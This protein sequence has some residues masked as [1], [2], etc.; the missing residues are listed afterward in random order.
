MTAV[1]KRAK[2][3]VGGSL[4]FG[5]QYLWRASEHTIDMAMPAPSPVPATI[6]C[7]PQD[8]TIDVCRTAIIVIDMQ[9]DF[10]AQGGWVDHLGVDYKPDRAPIA[11]LQRLLPV[12]RKVGVPV[13]WLNWGNRPD[14]ANMPPNQIHLYK[15]HGTGIG[16]GDPLPKSGAHVLEKDS[17][18]A[19]VVDELKREP[20]DI[21][22][23]KYRI[24]GFWDT[25]LD[26]ILRNLGTKSILFAGVNTD[27]CVLHSL[28]D[29]NFLGY[30]CILVDDCCATTSPAF[31][32][33]ATIWN[34]KKCFG[35]VTG[36]AAVIKSLSP[37][38][39]R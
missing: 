17:W 15:P 28:S 35:F 24:S 12:L 30:G 2:Q 21:K 27:Q 10:C 26:S 1:K 6:A 31:C 4:G 16:L 8:V 29:A 36:S 14:L 39:I 9:N 34:V 20:Q 5:S 19:R 37:L 33:E 3:P 38:A 32:T 25:P 18:A 11:P 22:V 23:D 13:I 7:A